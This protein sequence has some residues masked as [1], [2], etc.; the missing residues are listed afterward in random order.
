M[1]NHGSQLLA[2]KHHGCSLLAGDAGFRLIHG[3]KSEEAQPSGG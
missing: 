1:D 2:K 3:L